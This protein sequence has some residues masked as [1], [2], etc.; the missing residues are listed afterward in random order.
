M[1]IKGFITQSADIRHILWITWGL[2]ASLK[3]SSGYAG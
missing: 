3:K 2:L 1:R